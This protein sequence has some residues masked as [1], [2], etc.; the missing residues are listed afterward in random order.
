MNIKILQQ[1]LIT[2][3]ANGK[4]SVKELHKVD[5]MKRQGNMLET[6]REEKSSTFLFEGDVDYIK[7]KRIVMTIKHNLLINMRLKRVI[8][9]PL[10]SLFSQ[11]LSSSFFLQ[12]HLHYLYHHQCILPQLFNSFQLNKKVK[13]DSMKLEAKGQNYS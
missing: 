7:A 4:P 2:W 6:E 5:V 13:A 12:P 1:K 10:F 9:K 3:A 8:I 11:L